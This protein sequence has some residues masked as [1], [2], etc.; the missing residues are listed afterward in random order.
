MSWGTFRDAAGTHCN[1]HGNNFVL[2]APDPGPDDAAAAN[3]GPLLAPL[4][5]DF[6]YTQ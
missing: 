6:A 1:A 2:C 4:D 3:A 5:L